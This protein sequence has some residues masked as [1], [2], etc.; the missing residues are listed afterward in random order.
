MDSK[1]IY[2]TEFTNSDTVL[3]YFA[4]VGDEMHFKHQ[5]RG[6]WTQAI[7]TAKSGRLSKYSSNEGFV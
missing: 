4:A 5:C 6:R 1:R 2:H 7:S 3:V